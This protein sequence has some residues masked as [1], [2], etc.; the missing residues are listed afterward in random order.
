MVDP[1]RGARWAGRGLLATAAT[2]LALNGLWI[3]RHWEAL[4]PI[5]AGDMAPLFALPSIDSAG[6]L[7]VPIRLADL[8]GRV[9]LVDFWAAWCGPCRRSMPVIEKVFRRYNSRGFTVLS[10]NTD[11][12]DESRKARTTVAQ[13]TFPLVSDDGRVANLYKVTTIPHLLLVDHLGVVRHVHRG[14]SSVAELERSLNGQIEAL[15]A[16]VP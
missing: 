1:A 5:S 2:L 13:T 11:G 14:F 4:R 10:V 9:V 6:Q 8:R 12:P 15:L 3:A 7:G 16:R